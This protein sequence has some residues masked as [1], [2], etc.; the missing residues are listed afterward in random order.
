MP[1]SSARPSALRAF[2]ATGR[3]I[4]EDSLAPRVVPLGEALDA[5]RATSGWSD[6]LGDVPPLDVDVGSLRGRLDQIVTFVAQVAAGFEAADTTPDTDDVVTAGD[7]RIASQA[8]GPTPSGS[9]TPTAT[10]SARRSRPARS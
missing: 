10:W 4:D 5:F 2:E 3:A 1:T 9:T 6:W 8:A 7:D